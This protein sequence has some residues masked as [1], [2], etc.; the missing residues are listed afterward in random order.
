MDKDSKQ[1]LQYL[2]LELQNGNNDAMDEI[3][4]LTQKAVYS[5]ALSVVKNTEEAK[6]L[7]MNTY[8]KVI[9]KINYFTPFT[10][11]Y[12]WILTIAKNLSINESKK[13]NRASVTDFNEMEFVATTSD[14]DS[15]IPIFKLAKKY[16]NEI[17]LQI[18]LLHIVSGYKHREIARF[19]DKPL[20][21]VLW[22]YNNSI[23]K[24]KKHLGGQYEKEIF[25]TRN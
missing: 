10:N 19:L 15:D 5:M 16:L 11:G 14:I 6:D 4:S 20:G 24:L 21:T 3:Y 23:K 2:L 22:T 18:L 13:L 25:G 1:K 7:M 12:A 8:L 9:Q 17:E